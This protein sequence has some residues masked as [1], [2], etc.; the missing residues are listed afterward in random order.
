MQWSEDTEFCERKRK[1]GLR[2]EL[3]K[4]PENAFTKA[5]LML[6]SEHQSS[7]SFF[8]RG[9]FCSRGRLCRSRGRVPRSGGNRI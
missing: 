6:S 1:K 8:K 2:K 4:E 3:L 5:V 7:K 9:G